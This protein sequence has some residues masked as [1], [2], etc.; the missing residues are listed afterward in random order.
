MDEKI[1]GRYRCVGNQQWDSIPHTATL[2]KFMACGNSHYN[3]TSANEAVIMDKD[4]YIRTLSTFVSPELTV[5]SADTKANR[6]ALDLFT[7]LNRALASTMFTQTW[8]QD[9]VVAL[10][11]A[12]Q[13]TNFDVRRWKFNIG[14]FFR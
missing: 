9:Y 11:S 6:A 14:K 8:T 7:S 10:Q 5:A 4:E 12:Q 2:H 3:D 1:S 13:S